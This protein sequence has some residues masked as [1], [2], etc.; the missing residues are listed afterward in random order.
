MSAKTGGLGRA[1]LAA[2]TFHIGYLEATRGYLPGGWDIL[3]SLSVEEMFYLAFP[4]VA[5]LL[6]KRWLLIS[7]LLVFERWDPLLVLRHSTLIRLVRI[8]LFRR[9]GWDCLGV[10]HSHASLSEKALPVLP[11][12]VLA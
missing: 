2:L 4:L 8:L 3:W 12:V 5:R 6:R 11:S 7:L 1:L 10:P 9:D